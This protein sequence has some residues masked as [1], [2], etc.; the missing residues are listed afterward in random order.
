MSAAHARRRGV[1]GPTLEQVAALAGVGRGTVSR[2]VNRSPRVSERTRAA[3]Q[4]AITELGYTPNRAARALA[5]GSTDAV[6]LVVLESQERLFSEPRFAALLHG[7]SSELA[8]SDLQLMLTP[9]RDQRERDRFAQ[10]AA[11]HRMDGVLLASPHATDPLPDLLFRVGMPTVLGGSRSA[12]ETVPHVAADNTDGSRR[13][14]RHLLDRG[15]RAVA[16]VA[17]PCDVYAAQ[18]R[19]TGY[20]KALQESGVPEDERLVVHADFTEAGGYTAMQQLLANRPQLE[21]VFCASDVLAA[22]ARTALREAG[23]HVPRDVALAGFGDSVVARQMDPPLTTVRQPVE[24][25]G[26][27]MVRMLV[28]LMDVRRETGSSAAVPVSSRVFPVSL[29]PRCSG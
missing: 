3:V 21:A 8:D 17:G 12:A 7:I 2:V 11:A 20:R 15:R 1:P 25:I 5:A 19:L 6:T 22:G 16:V 14:V 4:E 9:V 13:A 18:C 27:E 26:R 28:E 29:I 10:H 23:L 24:E